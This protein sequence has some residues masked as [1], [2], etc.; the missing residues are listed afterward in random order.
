MHF[1]GGREHESWLISFS[2]AANACTAERG[3]AFNHTWRRPWRPG[4]RSTTRGDGRDVLGAAQPHV[5][6]VGV[7]WEPL[8]HTWR[9]SWRPGSR[10]T[11][12]G[13][14]R[15][16]L[17]AAQPRGDGR[18]VLGAAK[19]HVET[20]GYTFKPPVTAPSSCALKLRTACERT[21]RRKLRRGVAHCKRLMRGGR[22]TYAATAWGAACWT[23]QMCGAQHTLRSLLRSADHAVRR[24]CGVRITLYAATSGCASRC[25]L[26]L[27]GAHHAV[28]CYCGVC[29]TLY[30]ATAGGRRT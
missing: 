7:Y 20:V 3:N 16:V 24:D 19:P 25:T 30:A 4:S 13:D 23:W 14:G 21:V 9:R 18:G 29:F 10:S 12:R 11:T 6:T 15:G 2:A 28:C 8:D 17:G 26:R 27:R 22:R 5:E 1:A